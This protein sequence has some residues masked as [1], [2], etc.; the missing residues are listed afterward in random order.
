MEIVFD[1]SAKK[2]LEDLSVKYKLFDLLKE[3]QMSVNIISI[4]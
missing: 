1:K 2:G 4:G 3:V